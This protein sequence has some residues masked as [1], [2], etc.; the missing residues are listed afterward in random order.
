MFNEIKNIIKNK[1]FRSMKEYDITLDELKLKQT[2]GA[3]I[4]DVRSN[5]EYEEN[6]LDKSINIPEYEIDGKIEKIVK[7]KNKCIVVYCTSGN[8]SKNAYKKLKKMGY[9]HVFNL[10]GGLDNY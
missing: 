7:E 6:H 5:R 3:I 1:F 9:V 10:Y 2:Q 8:R 4:I